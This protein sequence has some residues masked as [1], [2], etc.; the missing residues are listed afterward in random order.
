MHLI[1]NY[2]QK[3]QHHQ[4]Y[5]YGLKPV[6]I[7]DNIYTRYLKLLSSLVHTHKVNGG[8]FMTERAY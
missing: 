5:I 6:Y 3:T 2:W 4:T 7:L 8:G 1:L